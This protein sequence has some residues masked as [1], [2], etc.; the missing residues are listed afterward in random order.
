MNKRKD[1]NINKLTPIKII[2]SSYSYSLY[3]AQDK[4][5]KE[6]FL[7]NRV[8][9][10]PIPPKNKQKYA[11]IYFDNNSELKKKYRK[12]SD[13][14]LQ[15][16]T[17]Q[18]V[19]SQ[20]YI[21]KK[22]LKKDYALKKYIELEYGSEIYF[23]FYDIP[24]INIRDFFSKEEN[25]ND[26]DII[27]EVFNSFVEILA[28][29][30]NFEAGELLYQ[31]SSLDEILIT[32]N[33]IFLLNL[34][35]CRFAED[36]E[37]YSHIWQQ[38]ILNDIL[39][40]YLPPEG[41]KND[42]SEF[43]ALGVIFYEAITKIKIQ[44][45]QE[46]IASDKYTPI[47]NL[48]E[49]FPIEIDKIISFCIEPL[50]DRRFKNFQDL[51]NALSSHQFGK[52][53]ITFQND[54]KK[55]IKILDFD[56]VKLGEKQSV[57]IA[58]NKKENIENIPFLM[59]TNY[60]KWTNVPQIGKIPIFKFEKEK[61]TVDEILGEIQITF[62][63]EL[64]LGIYEGI[65][66][67]KTNYGETKIKILAQ[68]NSTPLFL[69][70]IF[71]ILY[72]FI[73][74]F[75]IYAFRPAEYSINNKNLWNFST[76]NL[77]KEETFSAGQMT[78]DA[79]DSSYWKIYADDGVKIDIKDKNF[80]ILFE[81][82]TLYQKAKIISSSYLPTCADL[83]INFTITSSNNGSS[84]NI[85]AKIFSINSYFAELE[86]IK[87]KGVKIRVKSGKGERKEEI[88]TS[89]PLD[90]KIKYSA[91][92]YK[93]KFT[94]NEITAEF[95]EFIFDDV[96]MILTAENLQES[97]SSNCS[98]DNLNI[99]T[100][101]VLKKIPPYV[102]TCNT[103]LPIYAKTDGKKINYYTEIGEYLTILEERKGLVRIRKNGYKAGYGE[104]WINKNKLTLPK[105]KEDL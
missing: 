42:R 52:I 94:I 81:N 28:D 4:S 86:N 93:I 5:T 100:G 99:K 51:K 14:V 83:D 31:F 38:L 21:Y 70:P 63:I 3:Y 72:A 34:F 105:P 26:D 8:N 71:G 48:D 66:K 32:N 102:M 69:K 75:S 53:I 85:K 41:Y 62:P 9:K 89:Y 19:Q 13:K 84:E 97:E 88:Q 77:I 22:L 79:T 98:F 67:F 20:L 49:S 82:N 30:Y 95:N 12:I 58:V 36:L 55:E 91:S 33:Q 37:N 46:R 56:N 6:I 45:A 16:I 44:N 57:K 35:S 43:Y 104:G 50:E 24:Q 87:N 10:S 47:R 54:R 73:F 103:K 60:I 96:A 80:N 78:L 2:S 17:S 68:I 59:E 23:I 76:W 27:K 29:L 64:P 11:E 74:F 15:E 40:P 7:V 90:V 61:T 1:I 39:S 25:I 92:D 18:A 101:A 65:L